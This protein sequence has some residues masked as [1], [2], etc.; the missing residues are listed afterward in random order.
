MKRSHSKF[1]LLSGVLG[2]KLGGIVLLSGRF[3]YRGLECSF[4]QAMAIGVLFV[5]FSGWELYRY[6]RPL[7]FFKKYILLILG[8]LLSSVVC[9]GLSVLFFK[10]IWTSMLIFTSFV[11]LIELVRRKKEPKNEEGVCL[12][13]GVDPE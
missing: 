3:A 13:E 12:G 5:V 6:F 8:L 9:D 11:V 7:F 10:N 1:D 4:G 2:V